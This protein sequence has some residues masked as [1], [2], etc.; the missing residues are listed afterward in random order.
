MSTAPT[1]LSSAAGASAAE[2][3]GLWQDYR[4]RGADQ[5]SLRIMGDWCE[6]HGAPADALLYRWMARHNRR[7]AFRD[8]HPVTGKRVPARFSWQW[9]RELKQR[10]SSS[11]RD[12]LPRLP[13]MALPQVGAWDFKEH[14]YYPSEAEAL[15]AL[16]AA[17]I[18][19]SLVIQI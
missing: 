4:L 14:C 10:P 18:A 15:A 19:L 3:S 13:F 11:G 8:R 1:L 17:L 12:V 5:A 7:P 2:W 9:R 16:R 6:E